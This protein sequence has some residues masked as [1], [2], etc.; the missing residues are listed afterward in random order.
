MWVNSNRPRH[1]YTC[2]DIFGEHPEPGYVAILPPRWSVTTGLSISS[3]GTVK[4]AH[5]F[6]VW[7]E[8]GRLVCDEQGKD[9]AKSSVISRQ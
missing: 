7:D 8:R 5:D 4:Q 1:H 6:R 9:V 3:D 2:A